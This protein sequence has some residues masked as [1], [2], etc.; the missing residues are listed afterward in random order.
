MSRD[1][2]LMK[3]GLP[4]FPTGEGEIVSDLSRDLRPVGETSLQEEEVDLEAPLEAVAQEADVSVV[5][6]ISIN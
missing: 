3:G 6:K 2:P 5:A 1:L 4:A